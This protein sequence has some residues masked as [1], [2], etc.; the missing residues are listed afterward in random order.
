MSDDWEQW[1]PIEGNDSSLAGVRM[2]VIVLIVSSIF[3]F[4]FV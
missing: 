1:P 3:V 2:I 4:I